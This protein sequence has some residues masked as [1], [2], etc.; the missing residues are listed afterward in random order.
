VTRISPDYTEPR[1]VC[2]NLLRDQVEQ[3]VRIQVVWSLEF[4]LNIQLSTVAVVVMIK[5]QLS[6]VS[7]YTIMRIGLAPDASYR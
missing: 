5:Q 3:L 6:T 7:Y 2:S 1:I 4:I